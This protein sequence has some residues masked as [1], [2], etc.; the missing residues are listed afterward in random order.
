MNKLI[1]EYKPLVSVRIW[2][3]QEE[4]KEG[5]WREGGREKKDEEEKDEEEEESNITKEG[6][7]QRWRLNKWLGRNK[8]K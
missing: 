8:M 4:D 5:V 1:I 3:T 7:R 2:N 6:M